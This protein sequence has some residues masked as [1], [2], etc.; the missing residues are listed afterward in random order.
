[1]SNPIFFNEEKIN[2]KISLPP[3]LLLMN[4]WSYSNE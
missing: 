1:M 4:N 2:N 3:F